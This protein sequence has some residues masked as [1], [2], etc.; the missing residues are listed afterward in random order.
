MAAVAPAH[1]IRMVAVVAAVLCAL[2]LAPARALG[3][4]GVNMGDAAVL[5]GSASG[6]LPLAEGEDWYVIYPASG[7][8]VS[9]TVEDTTPAGTNCPA[10]NVWVRDTDGT[11]QGSS[12]IQSGKSTEIDPSGQ[13]DRWFVQLT[14][15]DCNP[16]SKAATSY[17]VNVTGAGGQV[18][19]G[20][21]QPGSPGSTIGDAG[22]PV[23][24]H[25]AYTGSLGDANEA[26]WYQ[27][28][29]SGAAPSV[30][31]RVSDTTTNG[32]SSCTRVTAWLVDTDGHEI[33]NWSLAQNSAQTWAVGTAGRYFVHFDDGACDPT[34][35][36]TATYLFQLDPSN[37]LSQ[38]ANPPTQ[39]LQGGV[40]MASAAGPLSGGIAYTDTIPDAQSNQWYEFH[41][42]GTQQVV[43]SV[44][45]QTK[46]PT[47]CDHVNALVADA[48]GHQVQSASLSNDTGIE[49]PVS[50]AGVYYISISTDCD[51]G[52]SQTPSARILLTGGV[53]T[54]GGGGGN[55]GG[56]GRPPVP[57]QISTTQLP[58]GVV[59][60]PYEAQVKAKGGDGPI[61]LRSQVPKFDD[62][63]FQNGTVEG[64][65]ERPGTFNLKISASD[66]SK[67]PHVARRTVKI[68]IKKPTIKRVGGGQGRITGPMPSRRDLKKKLEGA[69]RFIK[70]SLTDLER[71]KN[72][73]KQFI[74]V[75]DKAADQLLKKPPL[76]ANPLAQAGKTSI[77]VWA[78]SVTNQ[79]DRLRTLEARALKADQALLDAINR[80]Q[81]D[82]SGLYRAAVNASNDEKA[83]Q[84]AAAEGFRGFAA[85]A[86]LFTNQLAKT[87][88]LNNPL[89]RAAIKQFN[90]WLD[91]QVKKLEKLSAVPGS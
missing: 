58:T 24:G 74:A 90:N 67:P 21:M 34:G 7:S 82:I 72:D 61:V 14:D 15:G 40:S 54:S 75:F 32:T 27:F 51:P 1:T 83:G 42:D 29:V 57:L 12:T 69:I 39:A 22:G 60:Q 63:T 76:S 20:P 68:V 85:A 36:G 89:G 35:S 9:V 26:D 87:P 16:G 80:G 11:S 45:N 71:V 3:A 88:Q 77:D 19:Q 43:V 18:L 49:I 31:L 91:E 17:T 10:L 65:P 44:E 33:R 4:A 64:V 23:Q 52:S 28:D 8:S 47:N 84:F 37:G 48:D 41:A 81:R 56:G 62:I 2:M 50:K 79:I 38:P 46:N 78:Q 13:S 86:K 53:S 5:A 59:G 70:R 73:Y 6:D 25:I 30:T 66:S 55:P